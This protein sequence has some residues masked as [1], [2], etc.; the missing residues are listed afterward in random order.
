MELQVILCYLQFFYLQKTKSKL[1][2]DEIEV[3]DNNIRIPLVDNLFICDKRMRIN[4][5]YN[6]REIDSKKK[7]LIKPEI[8]RLVSNNLH[9]IIK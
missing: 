8:H 3:S 5:L 6:C 2:Y 7:E 9:K 1:F 4:N